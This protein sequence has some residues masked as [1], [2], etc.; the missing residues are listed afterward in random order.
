MASENSDLI[1]TF[2]QFGWTLSNES[3]TVQKLSKDCKVGG[4]SANE[5]FLLHDDS[6]IEF[7]VQEHFPNMN[8]AGFKISPNGELIE[9]YGPMVAFFGHGLTDK[10]RQERVNQ[11]QFGACFCKIALGDTIDQVTGRTLLVPRNLSTKNLID[12]VTSAKGGFPLFTSSNVLHRVESTGYPVSIELPY[13]AENLE[14]NIGFCTAWYHRTE[15]RRDPLVALDTFTDPSAETRL[16]H[17][18]STRYR[19][20][21]GEND[22]IELYAR[23]LRGTERVEMEIPLPEY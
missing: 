23:S 17:F 10:F 2:E 1:T 21:W 8:S 12:F 9:F 11:T 4:Y 14:N 22:D 19:V 16:L 13:D 7:S 6:T 5:R 15:H 3:S 20:E 18:V